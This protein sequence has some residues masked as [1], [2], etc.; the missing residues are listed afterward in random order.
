[1]C[2][3]NNRRGPL[4]VPLS[5]TI[6]LPVVPPAGLFLWAVSI[7]IADAGTPASIIAF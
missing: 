1:M 4:K 3:I 5:F 7:E 2:A 6:K